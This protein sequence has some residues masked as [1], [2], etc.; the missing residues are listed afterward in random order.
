MGRQCVRRQT[1]RRMAALRRSRAAITVR[2]EEKESMTD[3]DAAPL[4]TPYSAT[5]AQSNLT[6][7]ARHVERDAG[8]AVP[9]YWA[10]L[11]W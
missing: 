9:D 5:V 4:W 10:L 8:V 1:F 2:D 11:D 7:F 6:A 3:T